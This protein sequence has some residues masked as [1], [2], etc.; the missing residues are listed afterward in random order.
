MSVIYKIL[1]LAVTSF[2]DVIKKSSR[3]KARWSL[4]SVTNVGELKVNDQVDLQFILMMLI[5]RIKINVEIGALNKL[6]LL[7]ATGQSSTRKNFPQNNFSSSFHP[8]CNLT[9]RVLFKCR[10]VRRNK[11]S[12]EGSINPFFS[13][14]PTQL[15]VEWIT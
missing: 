12:L 13:R 9:Q 11:I 7:L 8:C 2:N 1:C 15:I 14:S 4:V 5:E 6:L 10:F 3:Q